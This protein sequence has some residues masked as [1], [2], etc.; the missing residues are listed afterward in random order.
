MSAFNAKL[1]QSTQLRQEMRINPRLYQAMELLYMPLLDLEQHLKEELAE[2]PFLELAE[3]DVQ[4]E[5]QL[6]EEAKDEPANGEVDWE[7][8]LL[9]GFDVGGRRAEYE[10]RD[11]IE[12]TAVESRD[13]RDY[14]EEQLRY[15]TLSEREARMGEEII[16]NL[17]DQG[18]LSC[19]LEDVVSGV[20]AWLV[21]VRPVAEATARAI[22]YEEQR[23]A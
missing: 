14:L 21:D 6:K 17:D 18:T 16:G 9:E 4:K 10:Q 12:P 13:L 20:N 1:Y 19:P 22:E 7:E 11:Y 2:N 23:E 8:I 5:V 15:L 3:A